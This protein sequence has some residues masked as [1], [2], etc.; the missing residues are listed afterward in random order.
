M[1]TD[2][3]PVNPAVSCLPASGDT[4]PLGTTTVTCTSTDTAGNLGTQTFSVTITDTEDP[5]LS[6]PTPD[7]VEVVAISSANVSY[8]VSATDN[9][10]L[11]PAIVCSHLSGSS[12]NFGT[13]I[14]TCTAT[15]SESNDTT[16]TFNVVV[17]DTVKPTLVITLD[18]TA[19]NIGDTALVTF[20]F[21]EAPVGFDN[22][23]VTV[24]NGT[25]DTIAGSGTVYTATLTPTAGIEDTTNKITVGTDWSDANTPTGNAP[26]G[27]T[28]SSNYEIDTLAPLAP[29]VVT[30][31]ADAPIIHSIST[32]TG[33]CETGATI[34]ISN[35]NLVTNPTTTTCSGS[36]FS[37]TLDWVG[38]GI[39]PP[40][41]LIFT[42]TDPSGNT[43]ASPTVSVGAAPQGGPGGGVPTTP[44][45]GGNS[46]PTPE[47]ISETT[48]PIQPTTPSIPTNN[49]PT[50]ESIPTPEPTPETPANNPEVTPTPE[51]TSEPTPTPTPTAPTTPTG[52]NTTTGG[53]GTGNTGGQGF[54]PADA[55]LDQGGGTTPE[56]TE[57]QVVESPTLETTTDTGG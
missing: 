45:N 47:P 44:T 33:T 6:L 14:V 7:P 54:N 21:S 26:V 17:Q 27:S 3:D 34:S 13:T 24:E 50:P 30:P 41:T 56:E 25:I 9:V 29:V 1:A 5:V 52:G 36:T 40:Q 12:F 19:L 48:P 38:T 42:Q 4:F 23:D 10:D 49:T 39:N 18:D 15:D 53:T 11:S 35:V 8:V 37:V 20:T 55:T 43:S 22:V 28:D 57:E 51:P 16:G 32:A 31:S 46:T 2:V